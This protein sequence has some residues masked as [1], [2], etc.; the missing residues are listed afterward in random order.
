MDL[1]HER[2]SRAKSRRRRRYASR[3]GTRTRPLL[4]INRHISSAAVTASLRLQGPDNF[5]ILNPQTARNG[6]L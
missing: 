3:V 4:I 5:H 6:R 2:A 1:K